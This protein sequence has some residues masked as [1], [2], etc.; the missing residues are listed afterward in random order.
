M[1]RYSLLILILILIAS[2]NSPKSKKGNTP[3][4][5]ESIAN[6]L[7]SSRQ[8]FWKKKEY[9]RAIV[10]MQ[11]FYSD[12]LTLDSKQKV[13]Y[14][15]AI[16]SVFY[17][18]S[19]AFSLINQKDSS[20]KYLQ[21][22][23]DSGYS[24]YNWIK[25]DS[26]LINIRENE[27]YLS[28]IEKLRQTY[29]YEEILKQNPTYRKELQDIPGY[30]YQ[31]N[32]ALELKKFSDKY[33]LD[34]V[35]GKGN[36][37]SRIIN[38]M[39]WVHHSVRHDGSSVNPFD[40]HADAIIELCKKDSRGVNCRMLATILNEVY[41]A[42]GFHSHFVT[43]LPKNKQDTD[44]H[45]INSVFSRDLNKWIWMDPTFETWIKDNSGN[46]LGIEEV[47]ERL[48]KG[49]PVYA[50][51]AINWNG[52]LNDGNEY[53]H[54]YMAKNLFQLQIPLISCAAFESRDLNDSPPIFLQNAQYR[55]RTYIQLIPV[56][57]KPY[58]IEPG[59]I[60]NGVY[61]TNDS[62]QFWKIPG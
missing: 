5:F 11:E 14:D 13:K 7:E 22:A 6:K 37:I 36:E 45:V 58:D 30:G 60:N 21:K 26:D 59:K 3:T 24:N 57:F 54:T 1:R 61:Y 47:R 8:I 31:S 44:C 41:L 17:N 10:V 56:E 23:V 34:S 43:C 53:L 55:N 35:A 38:L 9:A 39:S 2:C 62:K 29:D 18:L 20:V 12:Y 51:P 15:G 16:S 50:S 49:L 52:K 33:K 27:K 40:R 48:I 42:T 25:K 4:S 28:L 19:C 32:Q 46:F